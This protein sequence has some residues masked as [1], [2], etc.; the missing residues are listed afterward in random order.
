MTSMNTPLPPPT[1]EELTQFMHDIREYEPSIGR[2]IIK[3]VPD[4]ILLEYFKENVVDVYYD[5]LHD[6]GFLIPR[7]KNNTSHRYEINIE[8]SHGSSQLL[9]ITEFNKEFIE[10]FSYIKMTRGLEFKLEWFMKTVFD[11][12]KNN[13]IDTPVALKILY[14]KYK[15]C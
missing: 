6:D 4:A 14:Q 8:N 3:M 7:N 13:Y 11:I 12:N 2:H 1:T 9:Y 5:Y 15:A 10:K